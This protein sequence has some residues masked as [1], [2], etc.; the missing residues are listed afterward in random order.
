LLK[1]IEIMFFDAQIATFPLRIAHPTTNVP[2]PHFAVETRPIGIHGNH[3]LPA[4]IWNVTKKASSD[5]EM[6]LHGRPKSSE[7]RACNGLFRTL[8]TLG[9]NCARQVH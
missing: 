6:R 8:A 3:M 2:S 4:E 7:L 1:N 9:L 5:S